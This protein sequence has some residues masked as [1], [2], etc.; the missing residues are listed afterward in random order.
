MQRI[1]IIDNKTFSFYD[2]NAKTNE[3]KLTKSEKIIFSMIRDRIGLQF[4]FLFSDF[5]LWNFQVEHQNN[6]LDQVMIGSIENK[7][8]VQLDC[9][10]QEYK[11]VKVK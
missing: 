4:D 7:E 11:Y 2:L 10:N 5:T 9:G 1:L 3:L 8:R 6:T